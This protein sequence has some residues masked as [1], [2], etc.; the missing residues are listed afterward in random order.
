MEKTKLLIIDDDLALCESLCDILEL[1]SYLVESVNTAKDGMGKVEHGFYNIVLQDMKLP[2]SDGIKSLEKIREISP[3]TEVIMFTAYAATE[4]VIEA[5]DKGAFS[6][7]P[8]PFE[9][10][11]LRATLKKACERQALLFENRKLFKQVLQGKKEWEITFDSIKDPISIHDVESNIIR[12]NKALADKLET[13][14]ED[15]V[16][17][18]C[19]TVF[20]GRNEPSPGCAILRCIETLKPTEEEAEFMGGSF[21]MSCFPRFDESGEFDGIVHIARDI[22]ERKQFENELQESESLFRST[23]DKAGVG[24]AHVSLDGHFLRLNKLCCEI[25]GHSEE[26]IIGLLTS[27]DILHS[28]EFSADINFEKRL[29]AGEIKVHSMEKRLVKKNGS[30]CWV[31]ITVSL[32]RDTNK[33]PKYFIFILKDITNRKQIEILLRESEEKFKSISNSANDA[34]I[35]LDNDDSIS[36]W[37]NAA[38]S[39]FGFSREEMIGEKIYEKIIPADMCA[40]HIKGFKNFRNTGQGGVVGKTVELS[41]INKGGK[42]FPIELSLSAVKIGAKWN[43]IGIVRDIS[44]R[45]LAE[46]Q[47][48]QNIEKLRTTLNGTISALSATVEQRDPYTA[49]HQRRVSQLACVIADEMG[50]PVDQIEGLK[51]AGIVHDIGKMHI[52]AEILSRPG[53]L[54]KDEFNIVRS[55]A[56][57]GYDILKGIEFPWPVADIVYQHHEHMDGS[58]YPQGL[59]NGDILMEARILCVADVVEAMSSHRPYRPSLGMDM[60]L[61]EITKKKGTN[62]DDRVVLVCLKIIKEKGFTFE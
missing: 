50:L 15:I 9:M 35:M 27:K 53:K 25:I 33:K 37:N 13:T 58:G 61:E 7:L 51:M 19:N 4:S 45:K 3:D 32:V 1:D 47:R 21:L 56:Q 46:L 49:G 31:N 41:A 55:H 44:E 36:F 2:D 54:T 20:H 38:E 39:L 43:A 14:P 28:H 17:K 62:F 26:K 42:E 24:I 12:C 5:M 48:K 40:G 22:S 30:I 29:I 23:F 16:G 34:I 11:D 60:A 59:S 57:V 18:K 10:T 52:P 8:K 6:Y